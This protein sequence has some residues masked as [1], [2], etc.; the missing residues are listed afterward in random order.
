LQ[1]SLPEQL[2]EFGE[3]VMHE[4]S[5]HNGM[6]G[7]RGLRELVR[8]VLTEL[9][10]FAN[11]RF[12][13]MKSELQETISSLRVAAPLALVTLLFFFA[14]FLVFTGAAVTLVAHAFAGSPWAWFLA[15]IIIGVLWAVLGGIA[16][17]FAYNEIRGKGRFPKRTV[18][19]LKADKAWLQTEAS[20]IQG[21][22][23]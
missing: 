16:A 4:V 14:A 3:V 18:E 23:P 17:F 2:Y 9:K 12:E 13:V 15:F 10:E 11:T 20:S 1:L 22:R 6:T 21:V 5:N 8:E 19:V 7:N